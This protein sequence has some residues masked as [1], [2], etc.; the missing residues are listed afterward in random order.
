MIGNKDEEEE[1]DELE[2]ER[3]L[4]ELASI[5]PPKSLPVTSS[6]TSEGSQGI[7]VESDRESDNKS[8]ASNSIDRL[9]LLRKRLEESA[10]PE[11][12]EE[13]PDRSHT[14]TR[15]GELTTKEDDD[16]SSATINILPPTPTVP[17][18]PGG[19]DR[20]VLSTDDRTQSRDS[21][22]VEDALIPRG[23]LATSDQNTPATGKASSSESVAVPKR[24]VVDE[25]RQVGGSPGNGSSGQGS[26]CFSPGSMRNTSDA[27]T[28]VWKFYITHTHTCRSLTYIW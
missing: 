8:E 28:K 10:E 27:E 22:T 23:G 16:D 17:S 13:T 4:G 6:L 25:N 11:E 2:M 21:L 14:D 20:Y 18:R 9:A 5:V 24:V 19:F 26:P 3:M 12:I 7:E 15:L 1:E